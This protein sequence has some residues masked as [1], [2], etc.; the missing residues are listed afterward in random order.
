MTFRLLRGRPWVCPFVFGFAL[1]LAWGKP[2]AAQGS[3]QTYDIGVASVDITPDYPIRL[4]GFGS[5]REE[6]EGVT[7]RIWAKALAIGSDEQQPLV[8]LAVDSTGVP[9]WMVREAAKRLEK[10][11]GLAPERFVVTFTHTHTAPKI[12]GVCDTIFSAPIPEEH[13]KRIDRYAGELANALVKVSL[14]ALLARKPAHLFWTKGSVGFAINRRTAGGPVDHD[15]PMMVVKS[16]TGDIRAIY[17]SYACHCV[18]LSHNKIGGDWAGYAQEAIQRS[19]PGATALVSIGCGSDSNPSSGVTVDNTAAAAEQGDQVAV[20]VDRL[21]RTTLRPISSKTNATLH[22][23]DL[24]LAKLPTRDELKALAASEDAAGYNAKFQLAKLDRGEPLQSAI[25]YPIQSWTFGDDLAMVFLAGEVCVDYSH[26][27]KRDFDPSRIWLHGYSNDL[28]G[29]IPSERLLREGGYGGGGESV[30]F[31]WPTTLAAGLEDKI[32][33]EVHRQVPQEFRNE[34]DDGAEVG[35]LAP[36]DALSNLR[37]GPGLVVELAAAEPLVADPVAI[38]F[39]PD[40]RLWVAEM[41]DYSREVDEEFHPS[42]CVK[43]LLDRDH[44]GRFD[45]AVVFADRLRFPTD[46]K[47]WRRGVIVCDAPD[48][49]YLEDANGDGVAEVRKTLLTGFAT[50]NAQ[51]RVNSLRWGL[52]NWLYGSCGLFGGSIKSFSGHEV[53]LAACDFRFKPDIG[54]IEAATGRTQQGRT[55][56]DWG[57]WFGCENSHLL[58]HYPLNDSY[59]RRNPHIAPPPAEVLPLHGPDAGRLFPIGKPSLLALSGPPGRPTSVCGVEIYRDELLGPQYAGNAF[60]A[61]PVNQL[62]HRMV[63]KSDG[64]TFA[65]TRAE[66]EVDREFLAST[67]S[68]FRPVQLRT[69]L[70]GC[71]W[72]VDMHRAVIEH[73]RFIAPEALATM[74]VMAGSK[75]GRIYRVRSSKAPPRSAIDFTKLDDAQ[76]VAALDSPNGPQRDLAHQ[77]LVE[78]RARAQAPE[79]AKLATDATRAATRLQALCA[80]DG[81]GALDNRVLLAALSDAHAAVRAHAIRL[82]EPAA[83]ESSELLAAWLKR[84]D[85]E[86]ASVRLQLAYSLG[87]SADKR[88]AEAIVELVWRADADAY[89]RAAVWSSVNKANVKQFLK[90]L[91]ESAPAEAPAASITDAAIIVACKLGDNECRQQLF[92]WLGATDEGA[93]AA[94]RSAAIPTFFDALSA[95]QRDELLASKSANSKQIQELIQAAEEVVHDQEADGAERIAA[96]GVVRA[97]SASATSAA[98]IAEAWLEPQSSP[99]LQHAAVGTLAAVGNDRAATTLLTHWGGFSP[100]IRDQVLEVILSREAMLPALLSAIEA[101]AVKPVDIDALSRE[102]LLKHA[103]MTIRG[104]AEKVF[105]GGADADRQAVIEQYAEALR[106]PG[107]AGQGRAHFSKHCSSCHQLEGEGH[108]VGPD[109]AA[110]TNRLPSAVLESVLDPNRAVDERYQSY[111]ALT[112]D[113]LAHTG[114]LLRETATSITLLEPQGKERILLRNSLESLSNSGI[115]LMPIG[116]ERDL[117]PQ[118]MADILAYMAAQWTPPK[119]FAG[120]NPEIVRPDNDGVLWL[121][122]TNGSIFGDSIVFEE[123]F[124]NV[125]Y[126]HGEQDYLAWDVEVDAATTYVVHLHWACAAD[127]AGNAAVLEGG[128]APLRV[129]VANTDG[130]DKYQLKAI[131]ELVLSAG[132]H[133][134]V[135]RPDGPLKRAHLLDLRGIYLLPQGSLAAR[136]LAEEPSAAEPD[137]VAD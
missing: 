134:L 50:H 80:L 56:D 83:N 120:N 126:W 47:V 116:F 90:R 130:Y 1:T 69:G 27:L 95:K 19:Y 97:V 22:A 96:L 36:D 76:L 71:L 12:D 18:T 34:G 84:T 57:H 8:L 10:R 107:N 48:V 28:C 103:D 102:R 117:A 81:V 35:S 70:D 64:A 4:N 20:E 13:Q 38:D 77:L 73:R 14:D 51:A 114:M 127:S 100:T 7:Q 40:G 133:R 78:R 53:E 121:R 37:V 89:L 43:A 98:D 79:L 44:D 94:W 124:Q 68:W 93:L 128:E 11:A 123:P 119:K 31:G 30:Y 9:R 122:A 3:D 136:I 32:I 29:Y 2:S 21:L 59:L 17:V 55:R 49:I 108:T 33:A 15:L 87:A 61:E 105:A 109:L 52:D 125:G 66:E 39:G 67:E 111:N 62:V 45:E 25:D 101:G 135:M 112:D 86:D 24:P 60:V 131:G 74:D 23:I 16:P 75:R 58:K 129:T 85:D 41:P 5:R 110:L 115:S 42:G 118:D 65:A 99:E 26:R 137:V 63:L 82:S 54:E 6:S 46:V 106:L 88:A 132:R 104:K 72:V 113:G 91:V 92:A